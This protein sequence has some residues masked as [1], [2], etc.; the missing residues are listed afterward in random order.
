MMVDH[1]AL[2]RCQAATSDHRFGPWLPNFTSLASPEALDP[3]AAAQ[4]GTDGDAAHGDHRHAVTGVATEA[5]L[6]EVGGAIEAL[7]ND[8]RITIGTQ[9]T[10]ATKPENQVLSVRWDALHA[11][12]FVGNDSTA[13]DSLRAYP[14]SAAIPGVFSAPV[15]ATTGAIDSSQLS[16]RPG[17]AHVAVA[18]AQAPRFAVYPWSGTAWSARITPAPALPGTGTGLSTAWRPDGAFVAFGRGPNAGNPEVIVFPFDGATLG[19]PITLA[20]TGNFA[21]GLAWSPDGAYLFVAWITGST[22]RVTAHAFDGVT[23]GAAIEPVSKPDGVVNDV[24]VS[25]DGNWVAIAT[26]DS[27]HKLWVYPWSAG[28]FGTPV[29]RAT[30]L[31]NRLAWAPDMAYIGLAGSIGTGAPV[32]AVLDFFPASGAFGAQRTFT[33]TGGASVGFDVTFSADGAY[34]AGGYNGSVRFGAF[35]GTRLFGF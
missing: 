33:V 30:P 20:A 17:G 8:R 21:N 35:P 7:T 11:N 10:H 23:L 2:S 12:L 28:V 24:A 25:P 26:E 27:G 1:Q 22:F 4:T 16:V 14:F 5:Q 9:I 13:A 3:A 34:A 18:H 29:K 32:L 15:V 31:G 19:T 6:D